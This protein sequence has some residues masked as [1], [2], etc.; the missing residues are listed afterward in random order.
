MQYMFTQ[1]C[2]DKKS[3]ILTKNSLNLSSYVEDNDIQM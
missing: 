3:N 2:D 1:I